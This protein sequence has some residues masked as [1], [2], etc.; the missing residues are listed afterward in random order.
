LLDRFGEA[1]HLVGVE[2]QHLGFGEPRRAGAVDRVGGQVAGVDGEGQHGV[3]DLAGLANPGG[4]ETGRLQIGDPFFGGHPVEVAKLVVAEGGQDMRVEVR[5][6][7][8][9]GL[10]FEICLG[11]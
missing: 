8:G 11:D 6:V 2:E 4:P 10:G 3:E 7:P 1:I 5:A 9:E